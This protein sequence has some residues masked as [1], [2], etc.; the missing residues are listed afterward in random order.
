MATEGG[1]KMEGGM[2]GKP[3]ME[4]EG[5]GDGFTRSNA[6]VGALSTGVN[7]SVVVNEKPKSSSSSL[8]M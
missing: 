2:N 1:G 4:E 8:G 7:S 3:D 6:A 5:E